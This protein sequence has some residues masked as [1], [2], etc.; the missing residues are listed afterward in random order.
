MQTTVFEQLNETVYEEK[1]PNGLAVYL[2][3]KQGF[4]KTYAVFTTRYGSIDSH[5]RLKNGEEV[6][7]PDGIA[8]FL[9]H[10][11]FEKKDMDVMHEF[12]RNGASCNAF[13]SFNRTAYLFSCTEN[14][15]RNLNL[16]LDYVQEPY[17]TEASVEKEKG[18]IGQE[19]TMYDDNPD[20]KVYM[21]LLKAM[22]Q[23]FPIN[24]EIAGTIE[25]ISHITKDTLYQ[26][27]ETFYHPANMVLLVVGSFDPETVMKWVR[28]NQ[29]AKEFPPT[30]VIER[31]FPQEPSAVAKERIEFQLPVGLPKCLIGYKEKAD[32]L[33]GEALL[34]RDLTT[35]L[36]LDIAF[37]TS[38]S[39]YQKW[40]N[41]GLITESF[42]FDYSGEKEYGYSIMGGD[43]PDPDK[44]AAQIKEGIRQLQQAGINQEDF[45]RAKRKKIGLFLRSLNSVEFIANQFTSYKFNGNELFSVVPTLESITR[46]DVEARM[47]EHFV[48]EQMAVSIVRSASPQE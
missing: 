21:N 25:S 8:H 22:Y 14:L 46:E 5:F 43:T 35:K 28:D 48:P 10:K 39:L 17:F 37:G 26:C 27:Y 12:S 6:H 20:W 34:K 1:L 36:V 30:P 3:P 11:M 16:L 9:E 24:I 45:E 4:S 18:I 2:V 38:S 29:A 7:V 42:D 31:L 47:K 33:T 41:E 44:L 15:D 32:G 23:K 13:T 40:Y 19:I